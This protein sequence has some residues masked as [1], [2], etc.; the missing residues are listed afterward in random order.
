MPQASVS[1]KNSYLINGYLI[2]IVTSFLYSGNVLFTRGIAGQ[3]PLLT[4]AAS[5]VFLALFF[6]VPVSWAQLRNSPK[7]NRKEL[8]YLVVLGILGITIPYVMFVLGMERT[9]RTNTSIIFATAPAVTNI[10]EFLVHKNKLSKLQQLGILTSFLGLLFILPQG[11]LSQI[12]T[13]NLGLG[14]FF[15]LINVVSSVLFFTFSQNLMAKYSPLMV[16]LFSQF[17]AL[18]TLAPFALFELQSQPL[19]ALP[20]SHILT[21]LYIGVMVMGV[22]FFLNL[23]GINIVG[24]GPASIFSNLQH[25]ITISLSVLFFGETLASYHYFGFVLIIFGVV[26]SLSM[27][28]RRKA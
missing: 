22:G 26:L 13:L 3:I 1:T 15:I 24:S 14:E 2:L 18:L 21:V 8:A 6:L 5:R 27:Y 23:Y 25:I 12:L 20:L 17:F 28:K 10:L 11:S 16:S 9:T 7:P 4:F 19:H